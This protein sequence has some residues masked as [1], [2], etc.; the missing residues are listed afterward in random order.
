MCTHPKFISCA[1][2]WLCVGC[3][4]DC[5]VKLTLKTYHSS[6]GKLYCVKHVPVSRTSL[7]R[8]ALSIQHAVNVPKKSMDAFLQAKVG[9]L[10]V[11]HGEVSGKIA[12][13]V[14]KFDNMTARSSQTS[15]SEKKTTELPKFIRQTSS[16]EKLNVEAA[17]AS[18]GNVECAQNAYQLEQ[19]SESSTDSL[20]VS[21]VGCNGETD[22][23]QQYN[24]QD[25]NSVIFESPEDAAHVSQQFEEPVSE[26]DGSVSEDEAMSD[27]IKV[28]S[29]CDEKTTAECANGKEILNEAQMTPIAES[30]H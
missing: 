8:E 17:A 26:D 29:I 9:G 15:F 14:K 28:F 13:I 6:S 20:N 19:T 11:E 12:K 5:N 25:V 1:F 16:S 7:N 10:S 23:Q 30:L 4:D 18:V 22:K 21:D 2:F 3:Y 24:D 27:S